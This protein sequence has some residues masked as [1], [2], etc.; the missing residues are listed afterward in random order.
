MSEAEEPSSLE[1]NFL[2]CSKCWSSF[3]STPEF[4]DICNGEDPD[5]SFEYDV[6]VSD[7]RASAARGCRWCQ[8]ILSTWDAYQG[9]NEAFENLD[10]QEVSWE[11]TSIDVPGMQVEQSQ[12]YAE[13]SP[14]NLP[15]SQK[16]IIEVR[17]GPGLFQ[18]SFTPAGHNRF[19]IW[20]DGWVSYLTAFTSS[21]DTCSKM[22]TAR[23]LE[24]Q[25]YSDYAF[26]QIHVWLN[27][28]G[29]HKTCPPMEACELPTRVIDVNV[30]VRRL[31]HISTW[32]S[33]RVP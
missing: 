17:F 8:F 20:V 15:L 26:E 25:V 7:T 21:D 6:S 12:E 10:A 9:D 16:T 19:R 13:E 22:V 30:T 18:E 27:Q 28:C 4:K 23:Q 5:V 24:N 14:P 33:T 2:V 11:G 3:F 1:S 29:E 31:F 32:T